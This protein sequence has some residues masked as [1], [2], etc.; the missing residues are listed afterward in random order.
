MKDNIRFHC[1][2]FGKQ[3]LH[4]WTKANSSKE[5]AK[6]RLI[7]YDSVLELNTKNFGNSLIFLSVTQVT[8][9]TERFR[10]YRILKIDLV[11]EP[12]FWIGQQLNGTQ[13]LGLG[14]A[15]TPEFLN[16]ITVDNSLS[17]PM[18]HYTAP[19]WLAI[20][21]LRLSET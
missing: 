5:K 21:M 1:N 2:L 16:T 4:F 8:L 15:E 20:C 11:V 7:C 3:K 19:K 14:L 10:S 18:V 9:F 6:M 12:Y 17:F 13:L